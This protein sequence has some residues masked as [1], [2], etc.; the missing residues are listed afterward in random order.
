MWNSA[1]CKP[2]AVKHNDHKWQLAGS[3]TRRE[4][5]CITRLQIVQITLMSSYQLLRQ[6]RPICSCNGVFTLKPRPKLPKIK[7]LIEDFKPLA[8][9]RRRYGVKANLK[10]YMGN[11]RQR[12]TEF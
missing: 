1:H 4:E 7:A 10:E 6:E 3:I 12:K 5:V 11:Q 8:E 2:Y 9:L